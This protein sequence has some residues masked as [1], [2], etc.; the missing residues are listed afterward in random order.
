MSTHVHSECSRGN[1]L[2]AAQQ[3][4]PNNIENQEKSSALSLNIMGGS[5]PIL[6]HGGGEFTASQRFS[7]R[8]EG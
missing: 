6:M 1:P 3:I 5:A 7:A 2:L 8:A 4:F